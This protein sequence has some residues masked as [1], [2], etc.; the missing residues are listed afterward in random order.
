[1]PIIRTRL[2]FAIFFPTIVL[3][4]A[5]CFTNTTGAT[6]EVSL[7]KRVTI[8]NP[9]F[10]CS[11]Q[12]GTTSV[13][14]WN[15]QEVRTGAAFFK[16]EEGKG[17]HVV[18]TGDKSR[19]EFLSSPFSLKPFVKIGVELEFD[20][21]LGSPVVLIGLRPI[22]DPW[23]VDLEFI[24][25]PRKKGRINGKVLL[26]S[27][28]FE[29]EYGISVAVTGSG[30]VK[31]K[32]ISAWSEGDWRKPEKGFF[33]LDILHDMP[34]KDGKLG[35]KNIERLSAVFGLNAY[36]CKHYTE[37][38]SGDIEK[39]KHALVVLSPAGSESLSPET[40]K[41]KEAFDTVIDSGLPI[42]GICLGHQWFAK[43]HGSKI[44]SGKEWGP[45][46]LKIVKSD[47]IF[48]GLP[49]FPY[50]MCSQSHNYMVDSC[51]SEAEVLVSTETTR[52]HAFK[53]KGKKWYTF[54]GHIERD[55]EGSCPE[56]CVIMRNILEEFGA[57]ERK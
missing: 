1:M 38:K 31:L 18:S 44:I 55:W 48:R 50:F 13:T 9:Q 40:G 49:R 17:V 30:M 26:V 4:L 16:P 43:H 56:G 53:Y 12:D 52:N 6:A 45:Q 37:L 10:W 57:I 41:L 51:P 22:D 11:T 54:Q 8:K 29:G 7:K 23:A 47:P 21:E 36:D 5:L 34:P 35:W 20:V 19:G 32:E 27:G 46:S 25:M 14:D 42:L 2:P 39:R 3:G 33:V 15:W 24:E 28:G